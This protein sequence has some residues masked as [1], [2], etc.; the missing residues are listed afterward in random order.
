MDK[1]KEILKMREGGFSYRDIAASVGCGKTVVGDIVELAESADIQN[2]QDLTEVELEALL[3]PKRDSSADT[4]GLDMMH[5]I[6]EL[7]KK[8]VTRQLLWEE[9]KEEHEDGLMYSQFCEKIKTALKENELHYHKNHKAGEDCEVDWAGTTISYYAADERVW[10]SALIFVGV[11]PA[12]AYPFVRAYP[13]QKAPSWIDAH[14]RMFKFFGGTPRIL[15]PDCTKTAVASPDLFDPVITK[16][17]QEMAAHY[18]ITII[19]A[20][21]RKPQDY[22]QN[23]IIFKNDTTVQRHNTFLKN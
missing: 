13:D 16:T 2:V 1:I 10:K 23:H 4:K 20:R 12:S 9:Y 5:I 22:L 6:A 18:D 3:F 8:H 7:S 11:L 14:V 15:T 17:Y 19:P 21:P